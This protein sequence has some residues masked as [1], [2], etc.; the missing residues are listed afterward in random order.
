M[1]MIGFYIIFKNWKQP[2]CPWIKEWKKQVLLHHTLKRYSAITRTNC[3][4]TQ[5]LTWIQNLMS[6]KK[7]RY[8]KVDTVWFHFCKVPC[9]YKSE[10]FM[11]LESEDWK[12]KISKFSVAMEVFRSLISYLY[13]AFS[14][15]SSNCTLNYASHCTQRLPH[16]K[17]VFFIYK[18]ISQFQVYCRPNHERWKNKSP[19]K[20]I[21]LGIAEMSQ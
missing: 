13:P 21:N 18:K 11:S 1:P 20:I 16:F 3:Q 4:N 17:K 19:K 6:S 5:Q 10:W 12:E 14:N 7:A 15:S 2:D 8:Q 9:V